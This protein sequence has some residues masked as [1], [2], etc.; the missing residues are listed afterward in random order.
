MNWAMH[1]ITSTT[2][3]LVTRERTLSGPALLIKVVL[4]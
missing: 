2:Q 4:M 3:G 1:A